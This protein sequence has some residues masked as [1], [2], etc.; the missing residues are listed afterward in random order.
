[1][2]FG[3]YSDSYYLMTPGTTGK[4][5]SYGEHMME[6]KVSLQKGIK[7]AICIDKTKIKSGNGTKNSPYELEV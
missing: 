4:V 6:S 1:M 5:Y 3:D 2:K 7:P